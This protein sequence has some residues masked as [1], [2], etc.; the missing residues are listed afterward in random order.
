MPGNRDLQ[1]L[2]ST[3]QNQ[4][5]FVSEDGVSIDTKA[6]AVLAANIALMLFA[7]QSSAVTKSGIIAAWFNLT[8]IISVLL[9]MLAIWP[10]KYAGASIDLDKHP[11][12]L[13]LSDDDLVLQLLSD[14]KQAIATNR[15]L[16]KLRW[17]YCILSII[18]TIIG[19]AILFAIL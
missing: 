16:N 8:I 4:L 17:R 6:L 7:A 1:P 14:T 3:Q 19:T 10:R 2:L 18:F 9:D 12:Y 11:E 13:T 5:T 15:S